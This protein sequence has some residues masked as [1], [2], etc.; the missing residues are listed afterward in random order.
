MKERAD[1]LLSIVR[2]LDDAMNNTSVILLLQIK[3]TL[4]LFPGDAQYENWMY[5]LE[6]PGVVE[7]LSKV[8]VYKVGHHGS[9]NATPKTL[10]K[11]FKNRGSASTRDRLVTFL[12]T[13]EGPH[14]HRESNTEVPRRTLVKALREES[15][16]TDTQDYAR[17]ELVTA[18]TI[19]LK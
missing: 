13:K 5:A 8:N 14:G 2:I 10:W 3:N 15:Q 9:L 7:T 4:L 6:Q 18:Q 11:A 17:G 1:S 16:L 12:S 19:H